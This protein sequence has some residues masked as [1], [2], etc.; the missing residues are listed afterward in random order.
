L[1]EKHN[2]CGIQQ[3]I[4]QKSDFAQK[5]DLNPVPHGEAAADIAKMLEQNLQ[6]KSVSAKN[7]FRKLP[8]PPDFRCMYGC[9][10]QQEQTL[11]ALWWSEALMLLQNV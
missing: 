1:A 5:R 10:P 8:Q 6:Q 7:D 11:A 4:P 2:F 9:I 3:K